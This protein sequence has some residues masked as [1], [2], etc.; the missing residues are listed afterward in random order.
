M[1]ASTTPAYRRG[2]PVTATA[3]PTGEVRAA[4]R[5]VRSES[6][7]GSKVAPSGDDRPGRAGSAQP[8]G[9]ASPSTTRTGSRRRRAGL[10]DDLDLAQGQT[11]R[12]LERQRA[13]AAVLA[14][15]AFDERVRRLVQ[16][17]LRRADLGELTAHP[18]DGDLVAEL[19]RL[20]DV[21]GD[22]DDGLAELALQAEEELV[23]LAADHRID[24]GERL[25]HQQHQRIGRQGTGHPDA[26]LLTAGE[27][28]RVAVRRACGPGRRCPAAPSARLRDFC[29][30]QRCRS[31]HG[32]RCSPAPC[33]AGTA[34]RS[35]SRSPSGGAGRSCGGT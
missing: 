10:P 35:G 21:V 17:L 3:N 15:E 32:A 26:L 16:Q 27:L 9:R 25:V 24:R 8:T 2:P 4:S 20:V 30:S 22:H 28:R 7:S 13:V 5:A 31:G 33:D 19:D 11:R 18:Q 14:D 12:R 34:R 23:Q 1:S 29:L 6:V